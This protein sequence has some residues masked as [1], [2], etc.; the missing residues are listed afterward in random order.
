MKRFNRLMGGLIGL[1][2]NGFL[3]TLHIALPLGISAYH[4]A[5]QSKETQALKTMTM[6][7]LVGAWFQLMGYFN[8][9]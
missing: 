9:D 6:L 8:F 7:K 3:E 2:L 4:I 5:Q 1:K